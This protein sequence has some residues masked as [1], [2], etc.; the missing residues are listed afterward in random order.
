[1]TGK[2]CIWHLHWSILD[3]LNTVKCISPFHNHTKCVCFYNSVIEILALSLTRISYSWC[4]CHIYLFC[5]LDASAKVL[6]CHF[7]GFPHECKESSGWKLWPGLAQIYITWKSQVWFCSKNIH[8]L[9]LHYFASFFVRVVEMPGNICKTNILFYSIC[10]TWK[11]KQ[12]GYIC[13][14]PP[15]VVLG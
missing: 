12:F 7:P 4:C 2:F 15:R 14:L 3:S 11:I 13:L 5:S 8:C 10:A 9:L 6:V 1:M